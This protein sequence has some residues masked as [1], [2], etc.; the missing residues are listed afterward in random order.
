MMGSKAVIR[1]HRIRQPHVPASPRVPGRKLQLRKHTL[2]PPASTRPA[3]LLSR[4]LLRLLSRLI[5]VFNKDDF[6]SRLV[7]DELVNGAGGEEHAVTSG[8]HALLVAL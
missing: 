5:Q 6:V 4:C 2:N 8:A 7:V 1:I 3:T